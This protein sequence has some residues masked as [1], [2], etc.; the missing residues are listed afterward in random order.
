MSASAT[1][2]PLIDCTHSLI[3]C[4]FSLLLTF[5]APLIPC[6]PWPLAASCGKTVRLV[7]KFKRSES[8]D[9]VACGF[10]CSYS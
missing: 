7:N 10:T 3:D 2:P 8:G 1:P 5:L 4:T 6:T 9:K